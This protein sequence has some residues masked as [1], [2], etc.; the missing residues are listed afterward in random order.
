MQSDYR[1]FIQQVSMIRK[2]LEALEEQ[3]H[4]E[5]GPHRHG[6]ANLARQVRQIEDEYEWCLQYHEA[7]KALSQQP[8]LKEV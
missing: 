5:K 3:T 4:K 6:I 1:S 2:L 8:S 7:D